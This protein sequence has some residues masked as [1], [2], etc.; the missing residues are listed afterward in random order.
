MA[1]EKEGMKALD[2]FEPSPVGTSAFMHSGAGAHAGDAGGPPPL[3]HVPTQRL[4]RRPSSPLARHDSGHTRHPTPT[5]VGSA[6][7]GVVSAQFA[8][9]PVSAQSHGSAKCGSH[10]IAASAG[11]SGTTSSLSGGSGSGK[12]GTPPADV[13][14]GRYGL[15][16]EEDAHHHHQTHRSR[17]TSAAKDSGHRPFSHH[18]WHMGL[19]LDSFPGS[20]QCLGTPGYSIGGK[21]RVSHPQHHAAAAAAAAAAASAAFHH[22][23]F[24]ESSLG[25]LSQEGHGYYHPD[26]QPRSAP[27]YD[28]S[29]RDSSGSSPRWSPKGH[30]QVGRIGGGSGT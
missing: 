6:E 17:L 7:P 24:S 22:R 1:R 27:R 18:P 28:G 26:Q 29:P 12:A 15:P 5:N 21:E 19:G 14:L 4:L 8:S 30:R 10:G 23:R 20:G 3:L 16:G 13:M 9:L 2:S 11:S 25:Y